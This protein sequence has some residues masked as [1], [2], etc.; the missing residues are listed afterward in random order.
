MYGKLS[1]ILFLGC[2]FLSSGP[3][4]A[5]PD[6]SPSWQSNALFPGEGGSS[7][8]GGSS[9]NDQPLKDNALSPDDGGKLSFSHS[10]LK[11]LHAGKKINFKEGATYHSKKFNVSGYLTMA[12]IREPSCNETI[13][14]MFV[15]ICKGNAGPAFRQRREL[16]HQKQEEKDATEK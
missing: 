16:I 1:S 12:P 8:P 15:N 3:G 14:Q 13:T 4:S 11:H 10:F 6:L 9:S 5:F 7:S 2:F